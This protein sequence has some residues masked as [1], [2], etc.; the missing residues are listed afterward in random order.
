MATPFG[1]R[2][3]LVLTCTALLLTA[4]SAGTTVADTKK[5]PFDN[6]SAL[7]SLSIDELDRLRGREGINLI[8]IQSIQDLKTTVSESSINAGSVVSGPIT[9]ESHALDSFDG[10]GLF[11]IMTGNNNAVGTAVGISIYLA[12]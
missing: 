4:V 8:N 1:L 11:N 2:R 6:M 10:V 9:I 3:T 12:E 7:N 5:A